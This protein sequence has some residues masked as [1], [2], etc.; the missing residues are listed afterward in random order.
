MSCPNPVFGV[1]RVEYATPHSMLFDWD[2]AS[3]LWVAWT[4]LWHSASRLIMG[5]PNP[6]SGIL[7]VDYGLPESCRNPVFGILRVD[8]VDYTT[9][10]PDFGI[11]RVDFG[12]AEFSLWDSPSRLRV[13]RIQSLRFSE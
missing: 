6:V 1:L 10:H 13:A 9:P 4:S 12:T 8:W 7:R 11:L 5:C 3:G 2:S